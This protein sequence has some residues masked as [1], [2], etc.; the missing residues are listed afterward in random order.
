[1]T[2]GKSKEQK[3]GKIRVKLVRSQIGSNKH[4]RRVLAGLGLRRTN[5]VVER[6]D[7][8]AIRGM[9]LKVQHLVSVEEVA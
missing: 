5:Q 8:P 1:M 7:T 9:V 3:K 4:Q 2:T 6:E